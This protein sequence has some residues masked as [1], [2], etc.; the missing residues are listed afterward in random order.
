MLNRIKKYLTRTLPITRIFTID[1]VIINSYF[2][3][4]LGLQPF[5][6]IMAQIIHRLKP[7]KP[8]GILKDKID[9]Y[10]KNGYIELTDFLPTLE[11]NEIKKEF[12]D[13]KSKK[14]YLEFGRKD[15]TNTIFMQDLKTLDLDE[16][17]AIRQFLMGEYLNHLLSIIERREVDL[18]NDKSIVQFQLL[19]QGPKDGLIDPETELHS[20]TFFNTNKAW[21]YLDDVGY[22]NAPFQY[23]PKSHNIFKPG[24]L[25]RERKHSLSKGI[26][27]SRRVSRN[28][29]NQLDSDVK[30]FTC[31]ANTLL[32]AN[33]LGYHGR[34]KGEDGEERLTL[35]I[36]LRN[37]PFKVC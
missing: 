2:F 19:M 14:G 9:L 6:M 17:P 29:L 37:N 27:G 20:D 33:T 12:E 22:E 4:Y 10:D 8:I 26:S 28:E 25:F 1:K 7:R 18:I 16:Y 15:G 23:V 36:S 31:S 3:N 30:V 21:L 13:I 35:A 24:R 32:I 5:R 11:F 34:L